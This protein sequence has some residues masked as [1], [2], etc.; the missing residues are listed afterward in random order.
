MDDVPMPFTGDFT[1]TSWNSQALFARRSDRHHPTLRHTKQL[2]R[3]HNFCALQETHGAVGRSDVLPLPAGVRSFWSH[4]TTRTAGVGLLVKDDFL[5]SFNPVKAHDWE[6]VED[7]RAAVLRLRGPRGCLDVFVLYMD[8]GSTGTK[9][10]RAT[11]ARLAAAMQPPDRALTIL[12]GDFN[13]ASKPHDRFNK[14]TGE[15]TG[16]QDAE[17]QEV[18][19]R[20]VLDPFELHEWEQEH[21]T[22]DTAQARSRL[23]RVYVNQHLSSQLDRHYSCTPLEWVKHLSAHRPISFARR[24]ASRHEDVARP[25]PTGPLSDPSWAGRVS[26]RFG[27]LRSS[28]LVDDQPLRRLTLLKRAIRDVTEAMAEEKVEIT[29]NSVEDKLGWTIRFLRAAEEASLG[30]MA[31]CAAAYPFL[32]ELVAC[33][34]VNLRAGTSLNRVRDHALQLAREGISEDLKALADDQ[35]KD[36][37]YQARRKEH[38]LTRLKRLLPGASLGLNAICTASGEVT[39]DPAEMANSL[40]DHWSQVFTRRDIDTAQL[41]TWLEEIYPAGGRNGV[42]GL[43]SRSSAKWHVRKKDVASAVKMSGNTMPGPDRIP[44]KA[45]RQ[46]GELGI[47]VLH[48]ATMALMTSDGLT[49]LRDAYVDESVEGH[50]DFNLGILCCLP[51]KPTGSDAALGEYYEASSTRPLSIVNTDNRII[52]N[53]ARVRWEAVFNEW[54]SDMQRGFLHGRSMLSN[55]V[56][57]DTEAMVISLKEDTGA[58]VLFDFAAAFPSVSHDFLKIVLDHIGLPAAGMHLITALYDSNRCVI[59]CKGGLHDGFAISAGIRQGCPLSPLLFAVTVDLLLRT[60]ERQEAG[61]LVRAFA[62]DTAMFLRSFFSSAGAVMDVFRKFGDVSCLRLNLP[63]TVVVPLWPGSPDAIRRDIAERLPSWKEV[64]V[65]SA[66]RYLGFMTGPGK[67]DASWDKAMPK[68]KARATLWGSQALGLQHAAMTYNTFAVPVLSFLVQ[69][70]ELP[71]SAASMEAAALR[72]AAPGPGSWASCEDLW[73]LRDNYGQTLNFRSLSVM[74]LAAK[75]RVAVYEPLRFKGLSLQRRA[76]GLRNCLSSTEY[77]DRLAVWADWYRR[78]AVLV[79]TKAVN[80]FE[81]MGFKVAIARRELAGGAPE[82][83]DEAIAASVKRRFQGHISQ[84]IHRLRRPDAE[85]R[86]RAKLVRWQLPGVAAH[87]ARRVLRRMRQLHRLVAPRV[88]AAVFSLIWNRWTT[89]RRFQKR[90]STVNRCVLGCDDGAEDSIEHYCHCAAVRQCASRFLWIKSQGEL[91]LMHLMLADDAPLEDE[92]L[93]CR[94]LLVYAA[95][96]ATNF[97]RIHGT[98][99][100]EVAADAM[101]QFCKNAVDGHLQ[102]ARILDSRWLQVHRPDLVHTPKRRRLSTEASQVAPRRPTA[103]DTGT[104]PH[105]SSQRVFSSGGELVT[106]LGWRQ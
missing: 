78:A 52:A 101:A 4:D 10:R 56:D 65:S 48:S 39:A 80:D 72:R 74:S 73:Y 69:L 92:E 66:S 14:H 45:W 84:K 24:H 33:D 30:R 51:K 75:V 43:P 11:M 90:S 76:Y 35:G 37:Q 68:Y 104:R 55:V 83:W 49:M 44:Y 99:S 59:S 31:R 106:G 63:K 29:A 87:V 93:V 85:I 62:D 18:F 6:D 70:E 57:V 77:F 9:G 16:A 15:W 25:L 89:A 19:Q 20:I 53:A 102:S 98:C 71:P 28:D 23:D 58:L 82:P 46:L 100:T 27:E 88:C 47:D 91:R 38:I 3:T 42:R 22:C 60:L 1:G 81:R 40:K 64:E 79:L 34:D 8:T 41:R 67:G 50:H 12:V 105:S 32:S 96:R 94:A 61:A 5:S 36:P 54:V 21:F 103:H 86:V 7:G 97:Y 13:F 2:I 95:Y 26:L 17:D